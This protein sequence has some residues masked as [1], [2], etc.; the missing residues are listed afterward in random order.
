MDEVRL[1]AGDLR[2]GQ[3]PPR[4]DA[5]ARPRAASSTRRLKPP[6]S[7]SRAVLQRPRARRVHVEAAAD[8]L[9]EPRVRR[10][11]R[12][13]AR[14]APVVGVHPTPGS[15]VKWATMNV[16]DSAGNGP[17]TSSTLIPAAPRPHAS[18]SVAEGGPGS[19]R[20]IA[21]ASAAG[22]RGGT[23]AGTPSSRVV[24]RSVAA[25]GHAAG[26]RVQQPGPG[27]VLD[28]ADDHDVGAQRLG[29]LVAVDTVTARSIPRSNAVNRIASRAGPSPPT[30][31]SSTECRRRAAARRP[32]PRARD[33]RSSAA[34]RRWRA[35]ASRPRAPR[36]RRRARPGARPARPPTPPPARPI[37][38][39]SRHPPAAPLRRG[40]AC[41]R[42]R[43][44]APR[45]CAARDSRPPG[46]PPRRRDRRPRSPPRPRHAAPRRPSAG[47]D[48]QAMPG[49]EPA[50]AA[51]AGFCQPTR[52]RP[53][54][55]R[56]RGRDGRRRAAGR[57]A[58]PC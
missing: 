45:A 36:P 13:V 30:T 44:P 4:R 24:G 6:V 47:T 55:A 32:R 34:G 20:R 46:A 9:G 14:R 56:C 16:S 17:P 19:R 25:T 49:V 50:R 2:A 40:T 33:P 22:S 31:R 37:P 10:P 43:S 29:A 58:R 3:Q 54:R 53:C 12:R 23:S 35:V 8:L 28:R 38:P 1:E 42:G 51:R 41:R 5:G 26:E 7:A 11:R 39:P 27:A 48:R 18:R 15:P 52:R 21:P 57:S